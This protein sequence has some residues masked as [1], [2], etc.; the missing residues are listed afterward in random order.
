VSKSFESIGVL[1]GNTLKI[2]ALIAMTIDHVGFLLLP[3]YTILRVI[4][5]IS[6][7]IFSFM[8]AEGC[9]YTKNRRKYL[10]L[11]GLLGVA[12]Q[13]VYYFADRSLFQ[14]IFVS[15]SL[16]ISLIYA[17]DSFLKRKTIASALITILMIIAV[18]FVCLGLPNILSYTDFRIDYGIF[19]VFLPV[20]VYFIPS[21]WGKLAGATVAIIGMSLMMGGIQWYA[22][23][24]VLLLS[25]YNGKRGKYKLKNLF[26]W[27]Y[28]LHLI[29]IYFIDMF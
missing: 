11:I 28:P 18:L 22:L 2:I 12:F 5:R 23:I 1:S 13:L 26:Y 25:L 14:G 3:Q 20:L 15:F 17:I 29:V 4:G 27:Y 10:M 9:R 19:G 6:F 8:I 16:G 24:A 21:R 7:P